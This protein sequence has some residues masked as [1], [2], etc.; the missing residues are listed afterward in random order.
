M[1]VTDGA[2]VKSPVACYNQHTLQN[3]KREG[4]C[5]DEDLYKSEDTSGSGI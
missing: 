3:S 5:N 2:F 1:L 4:G